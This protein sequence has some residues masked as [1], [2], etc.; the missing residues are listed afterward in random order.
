MILAITAAVTVCDQF[1]KWLACTRFGA[2]D[3]LTVI[4]GFFSLRRVYN[5]GAAWGMLSGQRV[6]LV[7]VSA[8]ML[9][10]IWHNRDELTQSGRLG[11]FGIGLLC[12]G[13]VGNLIDRVKFGYVI[14]FL[15][16]HWKN[17]Y[18]FPT[19]NVADAAIF[20]GITAYFVQT[21]LTPKN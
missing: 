13:I 5:S 17:A 8:G 1:T 20:L 11:R 7:S 2:H 19:F 15:D 16:F 3:H 14:D 4:P 9:A 18:T 12:G 10:L 6:F 21:L